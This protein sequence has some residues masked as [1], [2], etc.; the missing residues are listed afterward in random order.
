M[1]GQRL[2]PR[3]ADL[4][5]WRERFAH[6]FR[7]CGVEVEVTRSAARIHQERI[8]KPWAVTRIE[9]RGGVTN[10]P[11]DAVNSDRVKK[12][13]STEV[14]AASSDSKIIDAL[15]RLDDAADRDLAKELQLS[16]AKAPS[17]NTTAR[18]KS[19][20]SELERN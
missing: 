20:P 16:V 5:R 1:D 6:D 15:G 12:W 14:K 17:L 11:P 7:E 3:K 9:E 4:Q 19:K 2:N 18:K 13:K 8:N 10:P